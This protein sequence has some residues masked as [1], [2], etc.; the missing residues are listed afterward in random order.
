[1][2]KP[3]YIQRE[4]EAILNLEKK[5]KK[6]GLRMMSTKEACA[7][8]IHPMRDLNNDGTA[9]CSFCHKEIDRSKDCCY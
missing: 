5:M 1:M 2:T 7:K 6:A 9:T 8:D 4:E 3:Y